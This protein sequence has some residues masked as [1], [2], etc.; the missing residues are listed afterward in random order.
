MLWDQKRLSD[1][2]NQICLLMRLRETDSEKI[3]IFTFTS[4][5]KHYSRRLITFAI[6]AITYWSY[7]IS[8]DVVVS[9]TSVPIN[10]NIYDCMM[11][12]S[13]SGHVLF[14]FMS[15]LNIYVVFC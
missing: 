10:E 1:L 5:E 14:V 9:Y 3:K 6:L 7:P 2:N 4:S 11:F 13:L 8:L 15:I 12:D